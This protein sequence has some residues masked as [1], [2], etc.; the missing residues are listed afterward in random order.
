MG[1]M[2]AREWERRGKVVGVRKERTNVRVIMGRVGHR[3]MSGG[4]GQWVGRE[5]VRKAR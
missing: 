1:G 2:G 5:K 3:G 4:V